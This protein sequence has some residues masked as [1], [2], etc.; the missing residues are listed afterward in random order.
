MHFWSKL[1]KAQT[2]AT[3]T[4]ATEAAAGAAGWW[5]DENA[6]LF[7]FPTGFSFDSEHNVTARDHV[8][9]QHWA[10][11]GARSGMH[12]PGTDA[13]A[14]AGLD[15]D[16]VEVEEV[17]VDDADEAEAA[18]VGEAAL[19]AAVTRPC[20]PLAPDGACRVGPWWSVG[21]ATVHPGI[22]RRAVHCCR[23]S[24]GVRK[25]CHPTGA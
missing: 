2:L 14:A 10:G 15:P 1:K 8:H 11:G 16:E 25:P 24:G 5:T 9:G 3:R 18:E 23:T 22:V 21:G 19:V 13:D 17:A 6:L 12:A 20:G 4:M 7:S